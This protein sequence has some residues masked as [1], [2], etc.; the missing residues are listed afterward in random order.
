[1]LY[2][3]APP[4][5]MS[6][7]YIIMNFNPRAPCG[8]RR[9]RRRSSSLRQGFNPR[10]P[11]GARRRRQSLLHGLSMFQST[12]PVW[13]ATVSAVLALLKWRVSIHAPRVGRDREGSSLQAWSRSFNPRAPCGARPLRFK[14]AL[15]TAE[16]Q[17]TRPVWGATQEVFR[18][19]FF[20][21]FQSTRPV[22]GA[23]KSMLS[24]NNTNQVSIH[25]P[26]V[27]RDLRLQFSLHHQ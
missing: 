20:N 26:R 15:T 23:T 16:F 24:S 25:A 27:G 18:I 8:A 12:R 4:F 7:L 6:A 1:M 9:Q 19:M 17:S 2:K 10:A 21:K 14:I 22:W 5:S 13:G 11:C 3:G